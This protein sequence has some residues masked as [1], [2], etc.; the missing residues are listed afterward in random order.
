MARKAFVDCGFAFDM[1]KLPPRSKWVGMK[2]GERLLSGEPAPQSLRRYCDP[3][4]GV[5]VA[6]NPDRFLVC[7]SFVLGQD[8]FTTREAWTAFL[9]CRQEWRVKRRGK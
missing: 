2:D 9:T 7:P 6:K 4:R 5:L 1:A 3:L 8:V